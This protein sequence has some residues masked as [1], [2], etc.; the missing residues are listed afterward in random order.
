MGALELDL[1]APDPTH[2]DAY[3]RILFLIN[4]EKKRVDAWVA[5]GPSRMVGNFLLAA[6][7]R[8]PEFARLRALWAK[9][10]DFRAYLKGRLT[11]K[12]GADY[13]KRLIAVFLA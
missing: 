6:V 4:D 12:F 1:T 11:L 10:G 7:K 2:V 3:R 8:D 13:T 9:D 5:A